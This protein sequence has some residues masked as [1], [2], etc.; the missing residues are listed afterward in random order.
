MEPRAYRQAL[1]HIERVCQADQKPR[2]PD[3]ESRESLLLGQKETSEMYVDI[4]EREIDFL[5]AFPGSRSRCD[6]FSA[7]FQL[8]E[9]EAA[10]SVVFVRHPL[11]SFDDLIVSPLSKQ[12]LWRFLEV[13]DRD[14]EDR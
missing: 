7:G 5:V 4:R 9:G 2:E 1:A 11:Q 3:Q 12:V 6:D 10:G 14:A 8:A 13:D